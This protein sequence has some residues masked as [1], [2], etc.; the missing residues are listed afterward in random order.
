MDKSLTS[1]TGITP[2]SNSTAQNAIVSHQTSGSPSQVPTPASTSVAPLISP[3]TPAP[4]P[5]PVI[6][7]SAE[8]NSQSPPDAQTHTPISTNNLSPQIT[9]H[10][11]VVSAT[12]ATPGPSDS[13]LS[14]GPGN[15]TN[16][17]LTSKG[18][19]TNLAHAKRPRKTATKKAPQP[20]KMT[21]S[22]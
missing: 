8:G 7:T 5:A 15:A 3:L 22:K 10:A 17:P 12:P 4:A 9:S 18:P 19:Q 14:P 1:D 21:P 2:R 20:K 11:Q 16:N 13:N 6:S